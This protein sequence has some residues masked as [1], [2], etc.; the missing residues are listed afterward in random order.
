MFIWTLNFTL[1][2]R[3]HG[4]ILKLPCNLGLCRV[5]PNIKYTP[6]IYD[7]GGHGGAAQGILETPGRLYSPCLNGSALSQQKGKFLLYLAILKR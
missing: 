2:Q 5:T 3:F 4:T 6:D 1:P 7:A